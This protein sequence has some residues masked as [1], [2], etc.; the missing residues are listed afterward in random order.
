[1]PRT[2]ATWR[3]VLAVAGEQQEPKRLAASSGASQGA[4]RRVTPTTSWPASRRRVAA[5]AL[6][7]PPLIPTTIL[8]HWILLAIVRVDY[9]GRGVSVRRAWM[10]SSSAGVGALV[11]RPW[12]RSS[13]PA[14]V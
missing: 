4:V 3:A 10:R 2:R 6:S 8:D 1:M 12:I 13:S 9:I 14:D 11:S 5:T 7:T